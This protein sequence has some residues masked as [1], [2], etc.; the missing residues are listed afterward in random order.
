MGELHGRQDTHIQG[1]LHI[2]GGDDLEV[3]DAQAGILPGILLH[4]S[5][6]GVQYLV[7]GTV[8]DGVNAGLIAVVIGQLDGLIH[9]FIGEAVLALGAGSVAVVLQ[10]GG[11]AGAQGAVA[12][13]LHTPD[14]HAVVVQLLG[15]G[16]GADV[17]GLGAGQISGEHDHGVG[18]QLHLSALIQGLEILQ[19]LHRGAR[20]HRA[21]E[22][23]GEQL[24]LGQQEGLLL[25]FN[26]VGGNQIPH[27]VDGSV[28][29]TAPQLSVIGFEDLAAL[30]IG[31]ILGDARQLQSLAVDPA[32]MVVGAD[33]DHRIVGGHCI[34][35]L[36]GGVAGGLPQGVQPAGALDP[37]AGLGRLR[38]LAH[39]LQNGLLAFPIGI[40]LHLI[41]A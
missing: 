32:H 21:G 1:P 38:L 40:N 4:D 7:V 29:E 20:V 35:L 41:L 2:L 36:L 27:Q 25:L 10:H 19:T 26:G 16:V 6:V 12:H 3:L 5:L 31:G 34:Q 13:D 8:T 30:G 24:L 11:G 22:A 15:G 9:L 28:G 37:L 23:I 18:A 39:Q 14:Q 33:Q 17:L